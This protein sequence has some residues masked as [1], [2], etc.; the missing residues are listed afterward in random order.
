M[1]K[2][3]SLCKK[4][5]LGAFVLLAALVILGGNP[6]VYAQELMPYQIMVNRAANCITVFGL[7]ENNVYSV[8]VRSFVCSTGKEMGDTPLGFYVTSDYYRWGMMVDGSYAQYVIRFNGSILFHSVPYYSHSTSNLETDQFNLLGQPASLGCVRL[9][10]SDVKWLYENCGKGTNVIVYDDA[11]NPGMLGKPEQM[12]INLGTPFA[13]WDPTDPDVM[14]PWHMLRP[15]LYLKRDMGDGV[16]YVPVGATQEDIYEAI[17]VET[18]NHVKLPVGYYQIQMN[19]NYDLNTLGSYRVWVTGAD[20]YGV[21][22]QKEMILAVVEME[23]PAEQVAEPSED[24]TVE[25][26]AEQPAEQAEEQ[27]AAQPAV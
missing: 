23:Q 5:V 22:V 16:L 18:F 3:V 4:F 20:V 8:P 9:A 25:Q 17:G 1:R 10:V 13:N 27:V 14:N 6:K 15:S 21:T 7:D 11:E 26:A 12:K 19:G 2:I 24:Q